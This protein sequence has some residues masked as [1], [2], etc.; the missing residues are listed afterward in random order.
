MQ[1]FNRFVPNFVVG[2][3]N[4]KVESILGLPTLDTSQ[5][6]S[7]RWVL[8]DYTDGGIV[9][10]IKTDGCYDFVIPDSITQHFGKAIFAYI[11]IDAG[12]LCWKSKSFYISIVPLRNLSIAPSLKPEDIECVLSALSNP[13]VIP[14]ELDPIHIAPTFEERLAAVEAAT[15]ELILGGGA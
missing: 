8:D 12:E 1:A 7:L 15:L 9:P 14:E 2:G 5:N 10:L 3:L 11:H 4:P 6:A 13:V